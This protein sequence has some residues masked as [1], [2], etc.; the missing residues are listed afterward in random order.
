[1]KIKIAWMY[2]DLLELYGDRG[3]IRVL[4]NILKNNQIDF[5]VDKITI[6][7]EKDISDY[8]LIFLGGG[9][10]LSQQIL[11]EDL[12]YKKQEF[13]NVIE[14]GGFILT[15]C[16]GY[17]M[18]GKYY[19]DAHQNKLKGLGIFDY[20]TE[21]GINRCIGNLKI[22]TKLKD[23][24]GKYIEVIGFENH[25]GQ[26]KNIDLNNIFGEVI[27]GHGN[28]YN[29]SYEGYMTENFLGTYIHG[30]LLPKN[31][32]I[33]KHIIQNIFKNKYKQDKEIKLT[34]QQ[35]KI[36]QQAKSEIKF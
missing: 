32:L 11:K 4:E 7:M 8:D 24:Q 18:F 22:K 29:S 31:P 28:E 17:Q 15:I 21:S 6:N 14:Q 35:L 3:N 25:G 26:T 30:P 20:Y 12:K 9:T 36:S 5:I 1:M 16:G 10:D 34:E 27:Y 13:L 33:A 19:L 23:D 2:Y